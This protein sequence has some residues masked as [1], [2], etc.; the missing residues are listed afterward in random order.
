M[1][2]EACGWV[3]R[4]SPLTGAQ[5]LVHLAIA[6]VV[7]DAHGNTF[8]MSTEALARK[9][10]TSRSTVTETLRVLREAGLLEVVKAGGQTRAPSVYKFVCGETTRPLSDAT[11][12]ESARDTKETKIPIAASAPSGL[13]GSGPV[14][15][16]LR[17]PDPDCFECHGSGIAYY[18]DAPRAER[19]DSTPIG[20]CPCRKPYVRTDRD[21][22]LRDDEV[23]T[24]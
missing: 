17:D 18:P 24:K 2:N 9:A 13:V 4:H 21:A 23:E 6:D 14:D 3:W 20:P 12:P 22:P 19:T 8:W 16:G 15:S 1:S 7:N 5:L 10:R 11:R